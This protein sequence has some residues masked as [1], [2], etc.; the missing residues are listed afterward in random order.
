MSIRRNTA[1]R[2]RLFAVLG[3]ILTTS[4]L[5]NGCSGTESAQAASKAEASATLAA[6]GHEPITLSELPV[7]PT[8]PSQVAGSCTAPTGCVDVVGP[9]ALTRLR[10]SRDECHRHPAPPTV[11][12]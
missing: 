3:A 1:I 11:E 8:A 10:W 2:Y 12:R 5:L 6:T 4:I 9:K 7:P